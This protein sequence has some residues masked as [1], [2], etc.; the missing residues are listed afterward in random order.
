MLTSIALQRRS[1]TAF[2]PENARESAACPLTFSRLADPTI[3]VVRVRL[4]IADGRAEF[5]SGVSIVDLA[6]ETRGSGQTGF[7]GH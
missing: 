5:R 3:E 4:T 1:E 7:A 6:E 2:G